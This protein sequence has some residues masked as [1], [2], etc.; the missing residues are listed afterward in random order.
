MAAHPHMRQAVKDARTETVDSEG[1]HA[2]IAGSLFCHTKTGTPPRVARGPRHPPHAHRI[3][4]SGA[5]SNAGKPIFTD[6][7]IARVWRNAPGT[8]TDTFRVHMSALRKKVEPDPSSPRY[9]VTE[10]WV[11]YRLFAEPV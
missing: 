2:S 4:A 6:Y 7:L 10:P 9:I 3:P 8:T 5:A 11:G 1:S